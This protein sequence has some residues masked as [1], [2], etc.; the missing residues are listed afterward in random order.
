VLPYSTYAKSSPLCSGQLQADLKKVYDCL[1]HSLPCFMASS[2]TTLQDYSLVTVCSSDF[3]GVEFPYSSLLKLRNPYLAANPASIVAFLTKVA[4]FS[5]VSYML[6]YGP[7]IVHL[8]TSL[9][10]NL[11]RQN[12]FLKLRYHLQTHFFVNCG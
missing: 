8:T 3:H 10:D 1:Y 6:N 9:L 11:K 12:L 7:S 2:K 4:F 5:L